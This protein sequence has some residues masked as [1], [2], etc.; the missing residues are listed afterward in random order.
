MINYKK[1]FTLTELLISLAIIG[2]IA[3]L[4]VP[5]LFSN[6]NNRVLTTQIKNTV[7]TMQQLA[8]DQM[9]EHKTRHIINTDFSD[10]NDLLTSKNFSIAQTCSK[11]DAATDCWGMSLGKNPYRA[12]KRVKLK[13]N[14]AG[15]KEV[16]NGLDVF[17]NL[18]QAPTIKLKNGVMFTYY[19]VTDTYTSDG[20]LVVGYFFLDTNG[21]QKPNMIGR[22]LFG[23]YITDRGI[24]IDPSELASSGVEEGDEP[25]DASAT[26]LD[27]CKAGN[28]GSE[29]WCLGAVMDNGWEMPY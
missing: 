14:D 11:T 9:L 25:E 15:T 4:T 1:A 13:E 18:S 2:A 19:R 17:T 7:E 16:E 21:N 8:S 12:L 29:G 5:T 22:D 23:F 24:I 3:A 27:K 28:V 6:I 20:D 26:K 10:P